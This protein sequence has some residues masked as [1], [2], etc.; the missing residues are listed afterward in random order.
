MRDLYKTLIISFFVITMIGLIFYLAIHSEPFKNNNCQIP[1]NRN[2]EQIPKLDRLIKDEN[3]SINSLQEATDN[4]LIKNE[5]SEK[6]MDLYL[7]NSLEGKP[8]ILEK[9]LEMDH[10]A[11]NLENSYKK[12]VTRDTI[13]EEYKQENFINIYDTNFGGIMP[14]TMGL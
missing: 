5:Q 6:E 3:I 8:D 2:M 7:E 14:T 4:L 9:T 1:N 10:Y 11:T 12:I 13:R